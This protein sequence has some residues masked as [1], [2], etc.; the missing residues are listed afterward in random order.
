[1]KTSKLLD[2][3]KG[4]YFEAGHERCAGGRHLSQ[5][6][7]QR[8]KKYSGLLPTEMWRLKQLRDENNKPKLIEAAPVAGQGDTAGFGP[9]LADV[10]AQVGT[11]C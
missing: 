7:D 10:Q 6:Q 5:E 3:L 1:M 8:R 9:T 4:V 2:A 11:A